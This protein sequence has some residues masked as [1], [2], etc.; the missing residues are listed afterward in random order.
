MKHVFT[1]YPLDLLLCVLVSI[2]IL[3]LVFFHVDQTLRVLFGLPFILFIPGYVLIFVLFPMKKTEKGIDSIERIALS[4]GLSI[5]VVPLIGLILNFTPWGIR[6]EPILLSLFG[7]IIIVGLL[8]W[9][10]WTNTNPAERLTV[11]LTISIPKA[12]NR[13][14][15]LLTIVLGLAI[16]VAIAALM[17]VIIAPKTGEKFTEFYLLNTERRADDYPTNLTVGEVASVIIGI[18]NH[19]YRPITYTVEVWL[20][21]QTTVYDNTTQNNETL[22]NHAWFM[23]SVTVTLNHTA[24][25][26]EAAWE[27]QFEYNYTFNISQKGTDLKLV[28]LLFTTPTD[29]SLY[30]RDYKDNIAEKITSAY[31]EIHLFVTV[32]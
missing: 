13:I 4:F 20:I 2:L 17:Y 23:D 14:D 18:V 24:V 16:L 26:I 5:A 31:R 1:R 3:P 25:D 29:P 19:E 12:E 9:Y 28:F 22:Y 30:N 32:S 11:S 8:G 15:R 10:R 27:P 21:N 6:L 7:F